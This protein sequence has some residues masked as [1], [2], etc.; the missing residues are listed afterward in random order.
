MVPP[1]HPAQTKPPLAV[2]GRVFWFCC[3]VCTP[4]MCVGGGRSPQISQLPRDALVD[5][6][7]DLGGMPAELRGETELVNY[8]L[9]PIRA[10]YA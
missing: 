8:F 4:Q 3:F 10:D 9:P 2:D 7:I 1:P 6:L 5:H